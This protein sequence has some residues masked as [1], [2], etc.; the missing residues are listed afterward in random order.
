M[1]AHAAKCAAPGVSTFA[2]SEEAA[3]PAVGVCQTVRP[4]ATRSEWILAATS[5]RFAL[6]G[7]SS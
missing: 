2:A 4:C 3:A 7:D 5:S 6:A 1:G